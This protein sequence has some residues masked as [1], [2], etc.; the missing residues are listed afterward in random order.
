MSYI[1][2]VNAKMVM[3]QTV[4]I[5]KITPV[6]PI[7]NI[8]KKHRVLLQKSRNTYESTFIG[9]KKIFLFARWGRS[10]ITDF[11]CIISLIGLNR[12]VWLMTLVQGCMV[13]VCLFWLVKSS[14]SAS[15]VVGTRSFQHQHHLWEDHNFRFSAR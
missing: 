9:N 11:S 14:K 5:W 15:F 2:C 3:N 10:Q 7:I 13:S 6:Q 4:F 1:V 12:Y 8:K